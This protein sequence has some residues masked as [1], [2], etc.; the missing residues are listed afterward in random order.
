[1]QRARARLI[2]LTTPTALVALGL[3]AFAGTAA[4]PASHGPAA[5]AAASWAAALDEV[6]TALQQ[7]DVSVAVRAWHDAHIAA[8]RA[9]E[10]EPLLAVGRAQL[11]IGEA[12]GSRTQSVAKAR[13]LFLDALFHARRSGAIDGVLQVGEQFASLG[14]REVCRAAL[15]MAAQMARG[16]PAASR[17][18]EA[19]A[20]RWLARLSP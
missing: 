11:R 20:E 10:W 15:Q 19:L 1:M 8:R 14:D 9:R 5:R 13:R 3:S 17:Q 12:S 16:N 18:I 2:G 4:P 6:D 7:R